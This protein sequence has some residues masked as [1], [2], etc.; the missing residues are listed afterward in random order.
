[1]QDFTRNSN[2]RLQLSHRRG[3][4]ASDAG[5]GESQKSQIEGRASPE[6]RS[7]YGQRDL[8]LSLSFEQG[9]GSLER[10]DSE[11]VSRETFSRGVCGEAFPPRV[12]KISALRAGRRQ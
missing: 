4:A 8:S 1:M 6:R 12:G 5:R 10:M 11:N 2:C 7:A 9:K 3:R